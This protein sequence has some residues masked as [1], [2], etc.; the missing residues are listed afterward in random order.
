M[1]LRFKVNDLLPQ[2]LQVASVV[3]PKNTLPILGDVLF[4]TNVGDVVMMTS[5]DSETWL[6]MK[7]KVDGCDEN[8]SF[9]VDAKNIV[10]SLRNLDPEDSVV[11]SLDDKS[12]TMR[13][14]YKNGYF[15]L[16]Y[17]DADEFPRATAIMM[18]DAKRHELLVDAQSFLRS[19]TSTSFAVGNDDL[20]PVMN[21]IRVDFRDYGM[22][23]AATDGQKLARFADT[24][25]KVETPYGV[26]FPTK[27]A[28]L[29]ATLMAKASQG[30]QVNVVSN[31]TFIT[32]SNSTFKISAR[33]VD[34]R[35]PNYEGVI[36]T[37]NNLVAKVA[38][39][40]LVGCLKRVSAFG[41]EKSGLVVLNFTRDG[42]NVS[43]EDIDFSTSAR[44][45]VECEYNDDEITIGFN[46]NILIQCLS[47]IDDKEI[48]IKMKSPANSALLLPSDDDADTRYISLLM[49]MVIN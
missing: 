45:K 15:E 10:S 3:K 37:D 12:H 31:D 47:N 42:L 18:D 40:S 35:Y 46:G 24:T 5:S 33:L 4:E 28:S 43:S 16:P 14:N 20:R 29:C 44:E 41:S 7:A 11:L 48:V 38:R 22:V 17:Q 9:C 27:P 21:G 2:M 32:V 39:D 49:P 19:I 36:P 30:E 13:L 23:C 25:I 34:G 26:T 8:L 1:E 6:S